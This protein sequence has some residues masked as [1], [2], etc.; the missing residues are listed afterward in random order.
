MINALPQNSPEFPNK[1]FT[2]AIDLKD[3]TNIASIATAAAYSH[4]SGMWAVP[5]LANIPRESS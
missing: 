1:T 2:L 3:T 4:I 5:A